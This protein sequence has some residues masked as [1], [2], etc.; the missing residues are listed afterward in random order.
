MSENTISILEGNTFVVSDR[1][2]NIDASP[3]EPTG[4]FSWDTRFLSRW[5][6]T[7]NGK[8]LNILSTDELDDYFSAQFFLAPATG[9]TYVDADVSV[10]RKRA[11]GKGFHEDL[12]IFNHKD[13]AVD[14]QLRLDVAADFADLFEVKDALPKKGEYT[15]RWGRT[16]VS[17]SGSIVVPESID[18]LERLMI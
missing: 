9:T 6:L 2:G 8:Q 5:M 1:R 3:T 7:I 14:L 15:Y 12:T 18:H 11:V 13:Q 17:G 4:L 10:I 16:N